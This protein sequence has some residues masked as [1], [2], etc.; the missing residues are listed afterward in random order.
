MLLGV[1]IGDIT[2]EVFDAGQTSCGQP[3]SS[4]EFVSNDVERNLECL[5]YMTESLGSCNDVVV[6]VNG[7]ASL[8]R[9]YCYDVNIGRITINKNLDQN[10]NEN[11]TFAYKVGLTTDLPPTADVTVNIV[12]ISSNPGFTCIVSPSVSC[13]S[14]DHFFFLKLVSS[15]N[16]KYN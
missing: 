9:K 12:A 11:E 15:S 16:K 6:T 2:I 13:F 8:P 10:V 3:C 5:Y 14:P 7:Q 1:T 4:P